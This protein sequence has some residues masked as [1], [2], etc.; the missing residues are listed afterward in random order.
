MHGKSQEIN[1]WVIF[2]SN[3]FASSSPSTIIFLEPCYQLIFHPCLWKPASCEHVAQL[4]NSK[5]SVAHGSCGTAERRERNAEPLQQQ[6]G[7]HLTLSIFF[8]L[9]KKP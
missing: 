8:F 1:A 9:P 2:V 3:Q 6:L 7:L 4:L 5:V